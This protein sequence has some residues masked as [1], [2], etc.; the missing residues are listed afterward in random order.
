SNLFRTVEQAI[1]PSPGNLLEAVKRLP[2]HPG[3]PPLESIW[4]LINFVAGE[5]RRAWASATLLP[6]LS[7]EQQVR[8]ALQQGKALQGRIP[9]QPDWQFEI[10]VVEDEVRCWVCHRSSGEEIALLSQAE[11]LPPPQASLLAW[12]LTRWGGGWGG[13]NA[14]ESEAIAGWLG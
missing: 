9:G 14:D 11:L 8:T 4:G 10:D 6:M 12:R 5:D 2:E 7:Q 3:L 13:A 1:H